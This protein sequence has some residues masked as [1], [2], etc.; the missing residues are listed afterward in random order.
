MRRSGINTYKRS[1]GNAIAAAVVGSVVG[2]TVS[3][4][5]SP[6]RG[7]E[8]RG[9]LRSGVSP[10]RERAKTAAEN[11]ESRAREL[12]ADVRDQADEARERLPGGVGR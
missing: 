8:M 6:C 10:A 11:I 1:T 3:P 5:T 9:R 2:A 7:E 4:L 12:A